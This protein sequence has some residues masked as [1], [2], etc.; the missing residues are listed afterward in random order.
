MFKWCILGSS[1]W[2]GVL[3]TVHCVPS[4]KSHRGHGVKSLVLWESSWNMYI[5]QLVHVLC[6]WPSVLKPEMNILMG[7]TIISEE[8]HEAMYPETSKSN[9]QKIRSALM[10]Q[11]VSDKSSLHSG[12][13]LGN[14]TFW[15]VEQL[16]ALLPGQPSIDTSAYKE[17][18]Y[19]HMINK[20]L[21]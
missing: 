15:D 1:R 7:T 10:A 18:L 12:L 13:P 17:M 9:H 8:N 2:K 16:K 3:Y 11:K 21:P 20:W 5:S 4:V 19:T 14:S 6:P